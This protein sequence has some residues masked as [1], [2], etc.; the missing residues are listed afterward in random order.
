MKYLCAEYSSNTALSGHS[1]ARAI[2][3]DILVQI[4]LSELIFSSMEL[5]DTGKRLMGAFLLDLVT[6]NF[7]GKL[8][9]EDFKMI[10][11]NLSSI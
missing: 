2:R 3:R 10:K 4:S 1:Y 11:K 7:E 5:S 6:E 8:Q 9:H